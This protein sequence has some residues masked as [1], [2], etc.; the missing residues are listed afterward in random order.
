MGADDNRHDYPLPTDLRTAVVCGCVCMGRPAARAAALP[1]RR[2]FSCGTC[3]QH[4]HPRAQ[5]RRWRLEYQGR[6]GLGKTPD[7]YHTILQYRVV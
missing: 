5:L 2:S 4:S 3:T 7:M 6:D 1:I